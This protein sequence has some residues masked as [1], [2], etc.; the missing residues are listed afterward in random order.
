M[1]NHRYQ[2]N[3]HVR[4]HPTPPDGIAYATVLNHLDDR[5]HARFIQEWTDGDPIEGAGPLYLVNVGNVFG[6]GG[7]FEELY[8]ESNLSPRGPDDWCIDA[9]P[10]F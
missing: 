3:D 6:C 9:P 2:V 4:V 8:R 5:E 1:S 7:A 10:P